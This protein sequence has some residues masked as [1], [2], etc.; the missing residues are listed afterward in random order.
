[1]YTEEDWEDESI[2]DKLMIMARTSDLHIDVCQ[3]M[4][5][6]SEEIR[7]LNSIIGKLRSKLTMSYHYD[8]V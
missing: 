7:K 5:S 2:E 3:L 6:A 4:D 1:M 8:V